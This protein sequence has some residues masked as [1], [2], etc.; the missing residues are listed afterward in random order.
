MFQEAQLPVPKYLS[1]LLPLPKPNHPGGSVNHMYLTS[2]H[3]PI[4]ADSAIERTRQIQA[5][6]QNLINPALYSAVAAVPTVF[7]S[8]PNII[9]SQLLHI[10]TGGSS[11]LVSVFPVSEEPCYALGSPIDCL[12][13]TFGTPGQSNGTSILITGVNGKQKIVFNMD[14]RIFP[15]GKLFSNFGTYVE[16]ELHSLIPPNQ[17]SLNTI[18]KK[19]R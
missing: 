19:D 16:A 14:T 5:K 9:A 4:K 3:W 18:D 2:I 11:A 12:E 13:V 1:T 7:G 17:D 6:L 15:S 10:M 8:L